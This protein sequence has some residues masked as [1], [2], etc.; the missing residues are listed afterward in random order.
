MEKAIGLT[1]DDYEPE[2]FRNVSEYVHDSARVAA[3]DKE[4]QEKAVRIAA[5]VVESMKTPGN[6]FMWAFMAD[7]LS[8]FQE[9]YNTIDPDGLV[10]LQQ[11]VVV[12]K[13]MI[14]LPN[15]L[16]EAGDAAKE[17]L[18]IDEAPARLG[19]RSHL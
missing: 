6:L 2:G 11:F 3:L 17:A 1:E 13:E 5:Q 7:Q 14:E 12:I 10:K 19:F 9:S 16:I 8:I 15:R 4:E 18:G